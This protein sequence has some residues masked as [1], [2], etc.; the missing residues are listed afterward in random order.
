MNAVYKVNLQRESE[1]FPVIL[2][3]ALPTLERDCSKMFATLLFILPRIITAGFVASGM[4]TDQEIKSQ[5]R[6]FSIKKVE[7]ND[8]TQQN[9][10]LF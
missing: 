1:E 3:S 5:F 7:T 8:N 2:T 4:I 10:R 9:W 6:V